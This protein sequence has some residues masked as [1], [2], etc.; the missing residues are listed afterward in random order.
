MD[1]LEYDAMYA[2]K[3]R[4]IQLKE[5]AILKTRERDEILSMSKQVKILV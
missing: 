5:D 2:G 1:R 3:E 4:E